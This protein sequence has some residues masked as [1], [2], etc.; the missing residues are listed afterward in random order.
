MFCLLPVRRQHLASLP[1]QNGGDHQLD[2][3]N[4]A[5]VELGGHVIPVHITSVETQK[6]TKA[7]QEEHAG[8]SLEDGAESQHC[9]V[10]AVHG[11]QGGQQSKGD[12]N[13]WR[14]QTNDEEHVGV[15]AGQDTKQILLAASK[16]ADV[17]LVREDEDSSRELHRD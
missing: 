5:D 13:Q 14:V 12:E 2:L 17:A 3:R 10:S 16:G 8:R 15:V 11:K 7:E 1:G 4:N 9:T 6:L